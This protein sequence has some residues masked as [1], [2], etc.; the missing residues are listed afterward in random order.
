MR[1]IGTLFFLFL[2]DTLIFAQTF[3]GIVLDSSTQ[4]QLSG[5]NIITKDGKTGCSTDQNGRFEIGLNK[6]D[7]LIISHVGYEDKIFR[8]DFSNSQ[9]IIYLEQVDI[10][11]NDIQISITKD[12]RL[13]FSQSASISYLSENQIQKNVSRSMAEAMMTTSG[14][15]SRR[16]F[17][18]ASSWTYGKL[19]INTC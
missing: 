4:F 10:L 2:I 17:I 5:V 1:F 11:I 15:A 19:Y 3:K 14:F 6:S 18:C 16:A 13:S 7:T 9:T 12:S 8:P